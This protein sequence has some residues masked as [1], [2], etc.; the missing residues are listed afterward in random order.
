MLSFKEFLNEDHD[1]DAHL[2]VYKD[3]MDK[4]KTKVGLWIRNSEAILISVDNDSKLAKLDIKEQQ[5]LADEIA[6]KVEE[7]VI[8]ELK[9]ADK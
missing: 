8:S 5:K 3:L 9:K 7:L 6:K 4:N 1:A 2:T